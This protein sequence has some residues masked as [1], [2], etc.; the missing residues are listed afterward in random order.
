MQ[1]IVSIVSV[2]LMVLL[3]RH[4]I[5]ERMA[6]TTD[7][8]SEFDVMSVAEK[9]ETARVTNDNLQAMEQLLTDLSVCDAGDQIKVVRLS[10]TGD[11]GIRHEYDLYCDGVNLATENMT[12]IAEREISDLKQALSYQCGQLYEATRSRKNDR[13]NG[14]RGE[15]IN[16]FVRRVRERYLDG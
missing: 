1:I 6:E 15:L 14:R 12:A 10:W 9:F 3:I 2:L 7:D 16:E 11:N 13:K 8:L 4:A 5:K